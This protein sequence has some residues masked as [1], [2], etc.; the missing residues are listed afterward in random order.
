VYLTKP[1][2][3]DVLIRT[4]RDLAQTRPDADQPATT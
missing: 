1:F 2:D 3:P 4:V